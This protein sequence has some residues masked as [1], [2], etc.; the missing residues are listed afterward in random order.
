MLEKFIAVKIGV[1][2]TQG[3]SYITPAFPATV[4]C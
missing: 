3:T 4:L 1:G 2:E